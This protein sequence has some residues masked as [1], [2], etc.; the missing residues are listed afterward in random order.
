MHEQPNLSVQVH[1]SPSHAE[2]R[3]MN[4]VRPSPLLCFP[5]LRHGT[6]METPVKKN[7]SRFHPPP[8]GVVDNRRSSGNLPRNQFQ[9]RFGE[10]EVKQ[11]LLGLQHMVKSSL[12]LSKPKSRKKR[13]DEATA[14]VRSLT[15]S[16][17][18]LSGTD[19]PLAKEKATIA[20]KL[21]LRYNI[22][23]EPALRMFTC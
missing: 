11:P 16:A 8:A 9:S 13:K 3:L 18:A 7:P 19:L 17:V 6:M 20:R 12:P 21:K 14:L 10:D 1:R 4:K 15:E 22:R 2:D 5:Q 23:L